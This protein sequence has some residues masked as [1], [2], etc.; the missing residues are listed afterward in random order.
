MTAK[1]MIQGYHQQ[2]L[3]TPGGSREPGVCPLDDCGCPGPAHP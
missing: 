3:M 2:G 1:R